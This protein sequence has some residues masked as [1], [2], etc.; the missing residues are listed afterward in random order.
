MHSWGAYTRGTINAVL[1]H[2][3]PKQQQLFD[4]QG[5]SGETKTGRSTRNGTSSF[6]SC[7]ETREAA[8]PSANALDRSGVDAQRTTVVTD[9]NVGAGRRV[10]TRVPLHV[11]P[12]RWEKTVP[13]EDSTTSNCT[14][15]PREQHTALTGHRQHRHQQSTKRTHFCAVSCHRLLNQRLPSSRSQLRTTSLLLEYVT[16]PQS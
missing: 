7:F 3:Q 1:V 6:S 14:A 10:A 4:R 5:G 2:T 11:G 13:Q 12:R 9:N 16:A 8:G 15:E